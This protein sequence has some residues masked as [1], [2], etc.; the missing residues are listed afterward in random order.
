MA[1]N[2]HNF[3]PLAKLNE[4]KKSLSMKTKSQFA[5][6]GKKEWS[7]PQVDRLTLFTIVSGVVFVVGFG[8]WLYVNYFL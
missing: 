6:A 4:L 5:S 1:E 2:A 8:F 7:L 3:T